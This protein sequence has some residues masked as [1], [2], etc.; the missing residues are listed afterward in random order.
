MR[1]FEVY[2]A[3]DNVV[4][5]AQPGEYNPE[6]KLPHDE[7]ESVITK[8]I[9]QDDHIELSNGMHILSGENHGYSD[10]EAL[11]IDK[12][13]KIIDH[14]SDIV[15]L[16][17]QFTPIEI[18]QSIVETIVEKCWK[19]YE[20]KGMKT[21]FGKRVPN[22]V[23]KEAVEEDQ[24]VEILKKLA[25]KYKAGDD[26]MLYNVKGDKNK[27]TIDAIDPK[28]G[29]VV[30]G[31]D[32]KNI[33]VNQ[34]PRAVTFNV[35]DPNYQM[36]G[37]KTGI[38]Q[39]TKVKDVDPKIVDY[40]INNIEKE[41]ERSRGSKQLIYLNLL[42][43]RNALKFK[44][45]RE[46]IRVEEEI[47][48]GDRN[49]ALMLPRNEM[50]VLKAEDKDYDR[51]LLVKLLDDGGYDMAYWYEKHV[52][53]EVEV[54]VDGKSIKKD[55]KVVT[56]KFHPELDGMMDKVNKFRMYDIEADM[57]D[58]RD[59]IEMAKLTETLEFGQDFNALMNGIEEGLA[60]REIELENLRAWFGKGKKGGAGGGGW[61]RY[62]TKGERIG[63]CGD[64]K[65]GEGKPK[66]LSKSRA[67]S[68][69]AK[70]GKAAIAAAVRK[71]RREDPN[72]NRKGKAKNV[73]NTTRK[74]KKK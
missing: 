30:S 2:Q 72:K 62:N 23:K 39:D 28:G 36:Q 51:G 31:S 58:L 5:M 4:K 59:K 38:P 61:D 70:G 63:K 56:M 17:Q 37:I 21:M 35:K 33:N 14:D 66:C 34:D 10:N 40:V 47:T 69:R 27:F 46:S 45:K 55:A 41:L 3:E 52:P 71:K 44:Q 48:S 24:T 68:L 67:A 18:D 7:V 22:C 43:D 26:L 73:S 60:E 6:F 12:D 25:Q 54:L 9:N 1:L 49:I 32:R 13:Y 74:K 42:A 64:S 19:G 53:F 8:W 16:M 50:K 11:V 57:K 15:D 65:K 29:M 20:K